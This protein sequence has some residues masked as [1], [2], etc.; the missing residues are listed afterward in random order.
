MAELAAAQFGLD[1]GGVAVQEPE[2]VGDGFIA[3]LA[4]DGWDGCVWESLEEGVDR[5][6]GCHVV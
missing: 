6:W 2:D 3:W 5:W 4:K 1:R